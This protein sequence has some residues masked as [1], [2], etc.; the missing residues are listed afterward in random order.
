[1]IKI[2]Y[3]NQTG[4]DLLALLFLILA[5]LG[6][7]LA[8]TALIIG[9][10]KIHK[11]GKVVMGLSIVAFSLLI[12]TIPV[13]VIGILNPSVNVY[14]VKE[15]V[16]IPGLGPTIIYRTVGIA[17]HHVCTWITVVLGS[18]VLLLGVFILAYQLIINKKAASSDAGIA[19]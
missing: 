11:I 13:G 10:R 14:Q 15:T 7:L 5:S 1:M 17:T 19:D 9:K 8:I 2:N 6:A 16:D 4:T 18:L 12:C 3:Y